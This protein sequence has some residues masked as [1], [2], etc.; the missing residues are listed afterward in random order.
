MRS[1][2]QR[3]SANAALNATVDANFATLNSSQLGNRVRG[4]EIIYDLVT[5]SG[6][7][8]GRDDPGFFLLG[9]DASDEI[10]KSVSKTLNAV[11]EWREISS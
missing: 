9:S 3:L 10:R 4:A 11:D 5:S 7:A 8:V 1:N 2:Y 6:C